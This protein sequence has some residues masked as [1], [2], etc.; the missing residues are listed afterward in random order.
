MIDRR[1]PQIFT[2]LPLT[3]LALATLA[4]AAIFGANPALAA[5]PSAQAAL[6]LKPVQADVDY[7][8][9]PAESVPNCKVKDLEVEGWFGWE[10]VAPDGSLLRR[11]ADTN[12]D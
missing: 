8:I 5:P 7:E 9:V 12:D 2:A 11:F 1:L 4:A 3:A 10:V 6:S